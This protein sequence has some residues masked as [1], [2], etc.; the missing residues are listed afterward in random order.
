MAEWKRGLHNELVRC[1]CLGT[2]RHDLAWI[3]FRF[4]RVQFAFFYALKKKPV[5]SPSIQTFKLTAV[6]YNSIYYLISSMSHNTY[7]ACSLYTTRSASITKQSPY[8]RSIDT[9]RFTQIGDDDVDETKTP[10]QIIMNEYN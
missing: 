4:I 3:G 5:A 6:N 9:P 8:R 2:A 1:H 7:Y 10:L